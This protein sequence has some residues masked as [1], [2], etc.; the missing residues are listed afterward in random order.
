MLK[1]YTSGINAERSINFIENKLVHHGAKQILKIY[2]DKNNVSGLCFNIMIDGQLLPFKLPARIDQC[3]RILMGNLS[4]KARPET[5]KQIPQQ[6]ARTAWKILADWVEAQMAM[7]ELAQVEVT[8]V[9]MP[10]LYDANKQRTC[11]E[12]FKERGFKAMLPGASE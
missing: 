5:R 10:Y 1:N 9:F 12:M 2:D 7:I 3:E 11:F 6:A 4:S 8:E